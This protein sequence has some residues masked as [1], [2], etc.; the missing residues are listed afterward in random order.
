MPKNMMERVDVGGLKV[1]KPLYDLIESEV[2]PGTGLDAADLWRAFAD[3]VGALA[4]RNR[5]LLAKRDALQARIDAWHLEHRGQ[6]VDSGAY[7]AFLADI[8]YLVPEGPAFGVTTSD[9]DPEIAEIA[10]PQLV[11]PVS[12]ARYALN[13]ANARWGSLYDALYGTDVIPDTDGLERGKTYNPARGA[14]VIARAAAFLDEAAPL[15]RGSHGESCGY[16]VEDGKLV[17]CLPDNSQTMLSEPGQFV[18]YLGTPEHVPSH[19]PDQPRTAHRD[20]HRSRAPRRQAARPVSPTCC[21]SRPS[22]VFRIARTRSPRSIPRTRSASIATG[23][24][25]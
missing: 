20:S 11:V 17:V 18:G 9:V 7:R 3:M 15:N 2:L 12:N 22:P 1:A 5:T 6:P 23:W 24:A 21:W 10:G 25:S 19:P 16:R 8:G 13:A 14:E 4:P